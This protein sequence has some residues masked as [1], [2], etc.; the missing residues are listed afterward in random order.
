M[1]KK[2]MIGCP[3][4]NRAWVLPRYLECLGKVEYPPEKTEYCFVINDCV[5]E[6]PEI[7][8]SFASEQ[9]SPVKLIRMDYG[10]DQGHDRGKYSFARLASLR[11]L[12]LEGFL[13]SDAD[14]LF[15]VDSDILVPPSA[16]NCLLEDD[17]DIVSALVCNGH[18]LGNEKIFNILKRK[19]GR[20]MHLLEFPRDKIFQVDCT[21]AAYLIK[22]R[23]IEACGV[24]Y[25]AALG[26]ED[27]GFCHSAG[28]KG[29][30]IFCDSRVECTHLMREND[31]I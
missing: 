11:N 22:R 13:D 19:N 30:K 26:A 1:N 2:V 21:G 23:V 7:L 18:E 3:V 16:L 25:S 27:I 14:Y 17:C 29:I 9:R 5:D 12:L 15:S 6:T 20:W 28:K 10:H 4:R 24:R 31:I 8:E